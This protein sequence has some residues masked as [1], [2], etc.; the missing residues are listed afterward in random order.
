MDNYQFDIVLDFIWDKIR[1]LDKFMEKNQPWKLTDAEKL[2][3]VMTMAV[4]S[5]K[6]I[7]FDLQPFLPDTAE[8]I[9]AQFSKKAVRSQ[10]PLFPRLD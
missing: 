2:V 3:K 6:Q 10:A 4:S 7:A 5:I 1:S 9:L 8:K